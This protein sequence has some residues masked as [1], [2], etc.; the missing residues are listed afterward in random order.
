MIAMAPWFFY[1][2]QGL[3]ENLQYIRGNGSFSHTSSFPA[4]ALLLYIGRHPKALSFG[5]ALC[6]ATLG[7]LGFAG[8]RTTKGASETAMAQAGKN[9]SPE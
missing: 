9:D 5:S 1:L 2:A 6:G 7:I 8:R 3:W 4:N